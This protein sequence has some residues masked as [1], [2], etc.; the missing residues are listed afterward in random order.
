RQG[1]HVASPPY[2]T[3]AAAQRHVPRPR[4][5]VVA[6]PHVPARR[7]VDGAGQPAQLLAAGRERRRGRARVAAAAAARRGRMAGAA[8]ARAATT[9]PCPP[10]VRG[11]TRSRPCVPPVPRTHPQYYDPATFKPGPLTDDVFALPA[12][13]NVANPTKCTGSC[14]RERRAGGEE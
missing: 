10:R 7:L 1:H 13:C 3:L 4:A 5:V 9:I 6:L 14:T 12:Y 8:T 11:A 2:A